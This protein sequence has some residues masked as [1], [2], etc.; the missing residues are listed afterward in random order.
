MKR[1]SA[2]DTWTRF[3]QTQQLT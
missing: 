1:L 2:F 3:R